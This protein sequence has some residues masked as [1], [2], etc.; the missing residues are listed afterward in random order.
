MSFRTLK[1]QNKEIYK[2]LSLEIEK[3]IKQEQEK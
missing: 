3:H 2:I 1:I